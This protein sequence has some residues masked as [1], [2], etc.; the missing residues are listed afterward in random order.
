[1]FVIKNPLFGYE[2]KMGYYIFVGRGFSPP[3]PSICSKCWLK[4]RPTVFNM[5]LV[6]MIAYL[7]NI[8]ISVPLSALPLELT[9][10]Q[11]H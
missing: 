3:M 4:P 6:K 9:W 7:T 5:S 1:M 11:A 2:L 10:Q 8:V